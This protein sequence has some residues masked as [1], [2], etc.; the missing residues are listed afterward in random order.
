MEGAK[1][2]LTSDLLFFVPAV[3]ILYI[4]TCKAIFYFKQMGLKLICQGM[5][6][7]RA[8]AILFSERGFIGSQRPGNIFVGFC[9]LLE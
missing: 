3:E 4:Y 9:F 1:Y 8:R 5:W 7:T 6:V 2:D